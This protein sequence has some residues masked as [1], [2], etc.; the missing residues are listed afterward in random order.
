MHDPVGKR[1]MQKDRKGIFCAS[2]ENTKHKVWMKMSRGLIETVSGPDGSP[3]MHLMFADIASTGDVLN[4]RCDFLTAIGRG[5]VKVMGY[6][7]LMQSLE[8]LVPLIGAYLK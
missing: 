6:M 3:E 5:N 2:I 4:G 8:L 1:I 7:P